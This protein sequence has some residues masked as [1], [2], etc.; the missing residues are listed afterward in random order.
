MKLSTDIMRTK[1]ISPWGMHLGHTKGSEKDVVV[2]SVLV[3]TLFMF[4]R[5]LRYSGIFFFFHA[6]VNPCLSL[7]GVHYQRQPSYFVLQSLGKLHN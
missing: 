3:H 2:D 1:H 6:S 4:S 7:T 5:L